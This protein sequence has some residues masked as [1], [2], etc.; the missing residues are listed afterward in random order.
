MDEKVEDEMDE[1]VKDEMGRRLKMDEGVEQG[2]QVAQGT[3]K[4]LPSRKWN[5]GRCSPQLMVQVLHM[6]G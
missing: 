2:E 1:K 5:K 6:S 3:S 4:I